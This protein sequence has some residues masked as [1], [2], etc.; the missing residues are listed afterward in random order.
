[1]KSKHFIVY[2]F[3]LSF[4]ISLLNGQTLKDTQD[5]I[6]INIMNSP[7]QSVHAQNGFAFKDE[8][9]RPLMQEVYGR[10]ITDDFF[11]HMIMYSYI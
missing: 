2:V 10:F 11:E 9:H 3:I 5:F 4:S 1:M 6:S 7:P 8:L